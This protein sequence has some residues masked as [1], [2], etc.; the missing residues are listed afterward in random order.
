MALNREQH[1]LDQGLLDGQLE[2]WHNTVTVP[3]LVLLPDTP[4]TPRVHGV[5]GIERRNRSLE[6][7][8]TRSHYRLQSPHLGHTRVTA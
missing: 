6:G 5:Q 4:I 7:G 1:I 3:V 2:L 8:R